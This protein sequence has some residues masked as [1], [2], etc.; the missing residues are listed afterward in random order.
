MMLSFY[1]SFGGAYVGEKC[2]KGGK[3]RHLN[4]GRGRRYEPTAHSGIKHPGRYLERSQHAGPADPADEHQRPVPHALSADF[5]LSSVEGVPPIQNP[6]S[7]GFMGVEYLACTTP[8]GR[9]ALWDIGHPRRRVGWK[10]HDA[11]TA[12]VSLRLRDVF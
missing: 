2:L 10:Q 5:Q 3:S 12:D 9:T 8:S 7:A 4:A 1:H 11:A 6:A